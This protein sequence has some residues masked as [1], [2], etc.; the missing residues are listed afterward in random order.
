VKLLV[1]DSRDWPLSERMGVFPPDPTKGRAKVAI[2]NR[3]MVD[4]KPDKVLAFKKKAAENRRT[5]MTYDMASG[6]YRIKVT[7]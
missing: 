6:L 2:R 7:V 5:Q 1:T 4:E 3:Q